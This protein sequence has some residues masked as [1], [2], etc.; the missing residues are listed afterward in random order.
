MNAPKLS[1][2]MPTR[3]RIEWMPE[4]LASLL[5]SAEKDIEVV[6]VDDAS[7]DGTPEVL[8]WFRRRDPRVSVI[9]NRERAGAGRSRNFGVHAATAPIIAVCDDDDLYTMDRA[10]KTLEWFAKNPGVP[11]V[12]FPYIRVGYCNELLETFGG[13]DFDAD[14]FKRDGSITFFCHPTAAFRKEDWLQIGGYRPEKEGGTTDDYQLVSDWIKAGKK[15][16]FAR[17]E[18]VCMHRVLP[19]SIM[20][21]IRGFQPQWATR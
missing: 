2:V 20:S 8:E 12:N 9:T 21:K 1:Y 14:R 4:C 17:D 11:M 18:F 15:I 7:D 16:G 3:N 19:D 10:T 5:D 13:A 6:V